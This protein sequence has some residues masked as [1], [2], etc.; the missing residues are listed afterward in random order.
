MLN[1]N[2]ASECFDSLDI[3]IRNRFAM[4]EKPMQPTERGNAVDF[5]KDV[6]KSGRSIPRRSHAGGRANGFRLE[7]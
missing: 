3:A 1:G 5:F 7:S 2:A 4:I 6:E